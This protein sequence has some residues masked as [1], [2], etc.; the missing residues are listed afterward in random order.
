MSLSFLVFLI[1]LSLF[2]DCFAYIPATPTN[3]SQDA[4]AGGLNVTDIS[5]LML[6]WYGNGSF[7]E[8]VS[9]Q[10][11]G[12]GSRGI[13]KGALVHFSEVEAN[14]L[15]PPT[16]TPWIALISCDANT[17]DASQE[18]DIFTLAK[19]KGAV[20]ALL[21]SLTSLT[22]VINPEYANPATFDHV[23]DI[24]CSQSESSSRIVEYQFGQLGSANTSLNAY[25]SQ[26][27][28]DTGAA[29]N[30]S[31][32]VGYPVA[33]GFL[34]TVLQASNAT[35]GT[36]TPAGS[37]NGSSAGPTNVS[38]VGPTNGSSASPTN[39]SSAI[40]TGGST[41]SKANTLG[42]PSTVTMIIPYAIIAM[43]SLYFVL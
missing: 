28:N 15:A 26:K 2:Q 40:P 4:I 29:I 13:S 33:P 34:Y 23:F 8:E 17:T 3:S 6:Q 24:F 42:A 22:C 41:A 5:K 10:L 16:S 37:T 30:N 39:E 7:L 31:I 1:T 20:A 12:N 36:S 43:F 25:D 19:D 18:Q 35:A 14:N 21:Y 9:Y 27:L 38:S 32:S 11:A